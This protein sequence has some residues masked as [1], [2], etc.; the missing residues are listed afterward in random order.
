MHG[1][2][3]RVSLH[4]IA[5]IGLGDGLLGE[6]ESVKLIALVVDL[7]LWRV[8]VLAHLLGGVQD[9]SAEAGHLTADGMNGENHSP[10]EAVGHHAVLVEAREAGLFEVFPLETLGHGGAVE[11]IARLQ[12]VAQLEFADRLFAKSALREVGEADRATLFVL[13]EAAGEVFLRPGVE[14]K[15]A[16]AVALGAQL[17]VREFP[18]ADFDVILLGQV[19]EGVGIAQLL[20]LHDEVDGRAALATGEALAEV[21]GGRDVERGVLVGMEGAQPDVVDAALPQRDKLGDDI[22][23]LCRLED[24]VFRCG[25]NHRGRPF[26]CFAS[27]RPLPRLGEFAWYKNEVEFALYPANLAGVPDA[28]IECLFWAAHT[29][30]SQSSAC[31]GP[32]TLRE[33]NR[34]L[35]RVRAHC[36]KPI[37]RLFGSAHTARSQSSTCLGLRR[38]LPRPESLLGFKMYFERISDNAEAACPCIAVPLCMSVRLAILVAVGVFQDVQVA[39]VT[40]RCDVST[41]HL[42]TYGAPGFIRVGAIVE[43]A[44]GRCAEDFGEVMGHLRALHFDRSEALDARRVDQVA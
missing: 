2:D 23:N 34:V 33:A 42:A 1:Y 25:I 32:R 13:H 18:F 10:S 12:T 27:R 17:V 28:P 43:A 40:R 37:E 35:V 8:E 36:A 4:Q 41:L 7:T 16:L 30:R 44:V 9:A 24:A 19:A 15:H 39:A 38:P 3:V 26:V 29:A 11:C 6:I 22:D 20:V 14:D 21:L 31:L 5:F